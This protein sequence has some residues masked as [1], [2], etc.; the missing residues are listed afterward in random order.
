MIYCYTLASAIFVVLSQV[1]EIKLMVNKFREPLIFILL[2]NNF[3]NW[4]LLPVNTFI[5]GKWWLL[6]VNNSIIGKDLLLVLNNSVNG[7]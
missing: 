2:I 1:N 4:K 6:T 7:K 3:I 5:N